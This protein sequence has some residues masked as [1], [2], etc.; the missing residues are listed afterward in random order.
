[1]ST[2][3]ICEFF[4]LVV[5]CVVAVSFVGLALQKFLIKKQFDEYFAQKVAF[6][7]DCNVLVGIKSD[8]Q[9]ACPISPNVMQYLIKLYDRT[10]ESE[11][12][13]S[14]NDYH[15]LLSNY[16]QEYQEFISELDKATCN[17]SQYR[18]SLLN[19]SMKFV[20]DSLYMIEKTVLPIY[21]EKTKRLGKEL[22]DVKESI[23][24]LLFFVSII[25]FCK[26]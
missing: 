8:V 16:G 3:S 25:G 1:M 11:R 10:M 7:S 18:Q 14:D 12:Y 19:D 2:Y 5:K 23:N 22:C 4:W 26:N 9:N 13:F 15:S 17:N 24:K 21:A 6:E 20:E